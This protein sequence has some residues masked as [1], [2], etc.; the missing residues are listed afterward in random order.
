MMSIW[1]FLVITSMC[2]SH[3]YNYSLPIYTCY[4]ATSDS[5]CHGI[6]MREKHPGQPAYKASHR[7][8]RVVLLPAEA[9]GGQ[10][11]HAVPRHPPR[12]QTARQPLTAD[13][14]QPETAVPTATLPELQQRGARSLPKQAGERGGE[15]TQKT[16]TFLFVHPPIMCMII[17][18][19]QLTPID[20]TYINFDDIIVMCSCTL[21][22]VV[23]ACYV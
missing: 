7:W 6:T 1:D 21:H 23:R 17:H 16:M 11:P 22:W 8:R 18:S 10:T 20:T 13:G 14:H 19:H 15:E 12:S 3:N 5:D 2:F 9:S 4:Y